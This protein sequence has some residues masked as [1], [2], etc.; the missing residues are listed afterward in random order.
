M[1]DRT[2]HMAEDIAK[3]VG[4]GRLQ[5]AVHRVCRNEKIAEGIWLMETEGDCRAIR[6]PGQFV[7]IALD[8]F[9]LRRPISVCDW[10]EDRLTLIY[11]LVGA[12]TE[13]MSRLAPGAPLDMLLGLG[14][15]F[16]S[17]RSGAAPLLVG[18]GVGVPPLYA[19]AKAL[20]AE[21]KTVTALFGFARP[22]ESFLVDEFTALSVRVLLATE[23]GRMGKK[24][25]VTALL[26]LAGEYSYTYSCGPEPMLRALYKESKTDGEYSFE[27]R[28]GCGFGACMGCSCQTKHGW[29]RI[30]KEGPVLRKEEI[31]W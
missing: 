24:G 20:V 30:C 4:T 7:N 29:K 19:L 15:G 3:D 25:H 2:K 14:N 8:G 10:T 31:L 18:G 28:M 5:Q 6:R 9:F 26:P 22:E 23:D 17:S 21:G 12:G 1:E 13:A 16:D 27:E 11:K